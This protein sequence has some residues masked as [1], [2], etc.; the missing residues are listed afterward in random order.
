MVIV[1][2]AGISHIGKKRNQNEDS[3][4]SDDGMGLY[5]V[6]DG[7]GGHQAGEIASKI[8]VDTI[9]DH[10][11]QFKES[12]PFE[13]PA[14]MDARLSAA[15][16]QLLS[17]IRLSN[18]LVHHASLNN[19]SYRGM[20]STVSAVYFTDKSFIAAN[21]GDS[22]IYL[23][24]SGKI[25]LLSVLHT[26]FA[27]QTALDPEYGELIGSEFKHVLTRAMGVEESVQAHIDE[28]GCRKNDILVISSDG[29]SDKAS[30]TEILKV[31]S[32]NDSPEA[33]QQLVDLA[34]ERGGDDNITAIV[35]KVKKISNTRPGIRE[36]ISRISVK[37]FDPHFQDRR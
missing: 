36:F 33:C 1:E 19:Q 11:R 22:P 13:K 10:I 5:I 21:V 2:S 4:C 27:E 9:R 28:I 17:G 6:A 25:E 24:R 32:D 30:P 35:L 7:M 23:I 12:E 34:N 26:V 37:L 18:R 29:L 3:M 14:R 20:G 15:A 16:N 31:V 8:V